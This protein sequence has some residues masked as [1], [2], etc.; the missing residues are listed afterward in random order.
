M[1]SDVKTAE[2]ILA[3]AYKLQA[4]LEN[5]VEPYERV[6]LNSKSFTSNQ[7]PGTLLRRAGVPIAT[8]QLAPGFY[9]DL[10]SAWFK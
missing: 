4:H 8:T 5:N 2:N 10:P 6:P 1:T 7:V 3:M 9:N